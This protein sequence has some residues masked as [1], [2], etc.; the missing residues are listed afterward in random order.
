MSQRRVARKSTFYHTKCSQKIERC[1]GHRCKSSE[2]Q[3]N[4][5][6]SSN[7]AASGDIGIPDP[8]PSSSYFTAGDKDVT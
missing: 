7:S 4:C 3:G 2:S 5:H 1:R 6:R 8:R